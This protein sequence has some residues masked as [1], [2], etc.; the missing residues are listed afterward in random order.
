MNFLRLHFHNLFLL[1]F[2]I[3]PIFFIFL[4]LSYY[5]L[6]FH[7]AN[8]Y[9]IWR[10]CCARMLE[11]ELWLFPSTCSSSATPTWTHP[12]VTLEL[13]FQ[14]EYVWLSMKNMMSWRCW[15]WLAAVEVHYIECV[16]EFCGGDL[17]RSVKSWVI[18]AVEDER[19]DWNTI[20]NR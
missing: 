15:R 1:F 8:C 4:F 14:M 5:N 2:P 3:F 16:S 7:L 18:M 10:W 19:H 9:V 17:P 11:D 6:F 20:M 13:C 12:L